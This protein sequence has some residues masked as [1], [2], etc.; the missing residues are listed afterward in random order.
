M[1]Q[2]KSLVIKNLV[3]AFTFIFAINLSATAT[4]TLRIETDG[5]EKSIYLSFEARVNSDAIIQNILIQ[6]KDENEAILHEERVT[7]QN[8]FSKKYNLENLP[9]GVY[10]VEI[11]D[12]LR[13]VIQ[14]FEVTNS[15][16][17]INPTTRKEIY[18][19]AFHF[20]NN[21][22]NINLLALNSNKVV[23]EIFDNQNQLI[24]TQK[25]QKREKT[26]WSTS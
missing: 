21:K 5:F 26:I 17:T 18:K 23:V 16:I 13:E 15:K 10:F 11:S 4:N 14:P 25:F 22:L 6:I 24:Y 8:A 20:S 7:D 1:T 3:I 9:K 12:D 19:P 2:L